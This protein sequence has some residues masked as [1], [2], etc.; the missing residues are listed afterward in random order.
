MALGQGSFKGTVR[1]PVWFRALWV[2]RLYGFR[3]PFSLG[4]I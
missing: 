2:L 1:V 4:F 3:V